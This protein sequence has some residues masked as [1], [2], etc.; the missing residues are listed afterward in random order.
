MVTT[1][2]FIGIFKT[3]FG[4]GLFWIFI[5]IIGV[6]LI[7]VFIGYFNRR[8]KLKYNCIEV[9]R[10]GNGKIG[11][12]LMKAGLFNA[13]RFLYFWDFGI[14][15]VFKTSDNRRIEG[16]KT[17][18]LHDLFGKKG[19]IVARNPRDP[20]ILIP[21]DKVQLENLKALMEIAPSD[22]RDASAKI[23]EEVV[24]ETKGTW[25]KILPYVAVGL[26]IFLCLITIIISM[27]ITN[28][29]INK[30]GDLLIKGCENAQNIKPGGSP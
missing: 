22:Y 12:N 1:N 10:F 17:S 7:A 27:Q 11:M 26:C 9:V 30:V 25:E 18:H 28:N 15:K 2:D 6:I 23:F 21:I 24:E 5:A 13:K 4:S 19:F 8:S 3:Y 16:A 20:K 29:A 14:E